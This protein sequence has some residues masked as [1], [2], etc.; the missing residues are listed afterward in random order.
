M[1]KP[2]EVNCLDGVEVQQRDPLDADPGQGLGDQGTDAAYADDTDI[3]PGQVSLQRWPPGGDRTVLLRAEPRRG[4]QL[5]VPGTWIRSPTSRT[6]SHHTGA[7]WRGPVRSQRRP[8]YAVS[9]VAKTR[10]R[11]GADIW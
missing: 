5:A 7:Y 3:Q 9:P 11:G 2:V 1:K 6:F 4:A 8:L 10:P